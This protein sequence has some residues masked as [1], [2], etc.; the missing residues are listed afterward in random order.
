MFN[1]RNCTFPVSTITRRNSLFFA[2]KKVLN[3][4]DKL[5]DAFE[6]LKLS[7]IKISEEKVFE[8][9]YLVMEP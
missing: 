3:H 5:M 6:E 1:I 2:V 9:Y 4:K 8:E 7:K